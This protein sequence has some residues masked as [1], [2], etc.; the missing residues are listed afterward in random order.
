M[1][2]FNE[3]VGQ[4]HWLKDHSMRMYEWKHISL[5]EDPKTKFLPLS[6]SHKELFLPEI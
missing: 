4:L 5:V 1:V 2:I 6:L 3:L